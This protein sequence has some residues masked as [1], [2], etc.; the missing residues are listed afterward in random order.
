MA[1]KRTKLSVRQGTKVPNK[2]KPGK[3]NKGFPKI[4]GMRG[5]RLGS[6]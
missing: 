2:V 1:A 4:R 3:F 5:P 6:R